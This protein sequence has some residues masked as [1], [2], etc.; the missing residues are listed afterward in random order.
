ME[1]PADAVEPTP[2][3]RRVIP[4]E[5]LRYVERL[6][7][8]GVAEDRIRARTCRR[9]GVSDKTARRYLARVFARLAREPAADPAAVRARAS[10]MLSETYRLAKSAVKHVTFQNGVGATTVKL[11][12]AVPAPEVGTMATV[13]ARLVE[14][15]GA[16]APKRVDVKVDA[17]V[18]VSDAREQLAAQLA[19]A[20]TVA[21]ADAAVG[22]DG[23]AVAGGGGDPPP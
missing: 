20:A 18:T 1:A 19:R 22:G 11:T 14:I 2:P 21:V 12:K 8:S 15:H 9:F 13:A 23:G 7:L 16:A 5:R 4:P 3:P 17:N 6:Y 10:A